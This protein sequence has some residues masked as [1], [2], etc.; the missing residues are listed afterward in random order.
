MSRFVFEAILSMF[1]L[2]YTLV[3]LHACAVVPYAPAQIPVTGVPAAPGENRAIVNILQSR[4]DISLPLQQAVYIYSSINPNALINVHTVAGAS[5]YRIALRTRL[6]AGGR[7]DVFHI[8]SGQEAR[9][10]SAHLED[11]SSLAWVSGAVESLAEPVSFDGGVFGIPYSLEAHGLI[12]NRNIFEVAGIPLMDVVD[13]ESLEAAM[14]KL[15]DMISSGEITGQFP[16]LRNVTDLPIQDRAYLGRVASGI[17]LTG[18]FDNT[19]QA[20]V[21]NNVNLP[22][23]RSAEQFFHLMRRHSP[24]GDWTQRDGLSYLY[25][26][27]DFA[28]GHTAMLL[29][30]MEG[31]L[32]ILEMNPELEGRI[33][34]MPIPLPGVGRGGIHTGTP[35]WW[36]VNADSSDAAKQSAKDFLTWLYTSEQGSAIVAARFGALS[37]FPETAKETGL[38]IHRQML[39]LSAAGHTA[40]QVWREAPAEWPAT[41]T[42]GLREWHTGQRPWEEMLIDLRELWA[43]RNIV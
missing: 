18:E 4:P 7:V 40:P 24:A 17:L 32:N 25:Q 14:Y 10:L 41:F 22:H 8:F 43:F 26:L 35:L 39:F 42:E 6:L 19:A 16:A 31:M 9:E 12:A 37:A 23:G 38:S 1:A 20:A 33:E 30:D 5:D 28:A 11:L 21:A 13:F 36:A 15:S 3:S 29:S 2:M 27:E 34:L